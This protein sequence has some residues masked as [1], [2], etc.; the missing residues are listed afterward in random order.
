MELE[1]PSAIPPYLL[2]SNEAEAPAFRLLTTPA[3]DPVKI[4]L[5][6]D[7]CEFPE[8]GVEDMRAIESL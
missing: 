1:A 6:L 3:M 2:G 8:V 7:P 4:K 5:S